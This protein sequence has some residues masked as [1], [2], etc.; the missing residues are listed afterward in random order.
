M[1]T[2]LWDINNPEGYGNRSGYYKTQIEYDFIRSHIPDPKQMILDMGG[3]SGRFALPLVELG[4]DLTVIDLDSNA[5]DICKQNGIEKSFNCDIRNF[6]SGF[7]DVVLAME[8]FLVTP[9][10]EV[11]DVANRKLLMNGTFIFV[12]TNKKSWRYKLHNL[13]I[14]KSKNY[15]EFS[16]KEYKGLISKFGFSV[17]DVKGFNWIPFRVNSNN[18]LISGFAKIENILRLNKW[19][20][21]SPW[22][23]F[24]CRKNKNIV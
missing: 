23:I 1:N 18:I 6:D 2:Y 22:L 17:I 20:D 24:A 11:F 15:G 12:A 7:F 3:G 8:L 5:I 21:Q 4:Y 19:L 9:P 14:R 13:R 16:L 10:H